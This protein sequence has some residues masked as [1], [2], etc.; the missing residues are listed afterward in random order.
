MDNNNTAYRV[1]MRMMHRR[2]IGPKN[3]IV[4]FLQYSPPPV[5]DNIM[6]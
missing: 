6:S 2:R 3:E 4:F 5:I 1:I